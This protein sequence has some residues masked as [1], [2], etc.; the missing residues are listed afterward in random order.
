VTYL[1][2]VVAVVLG[3]LVLGEPVSWTL[4]AGTALV[5]LGI[6][7]AEGRMRNLLRLDKRPSR[8][9]VTRMRLELPGLDFAVAKE[10]A[11]MLGAGTVGFAHAMGV[12]AGDL[13]AAVAHGRLQ[14]DLAC[15]G[16]RRRRSRRIQTG[17]LG[18]SG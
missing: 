12:D 17:P 16:W 7:V 10:G 4:F 3:I 5:L 13:Q 1:L 9:P 6:A 8:R 15:S 11:H 18:S 14:T 2:P